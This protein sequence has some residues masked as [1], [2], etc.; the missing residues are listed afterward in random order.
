[1]FATAHYICTPSD[2]APV[3]PS[4]GKIPSMGDLNRSTLTAHEVGTRGWLGWRFCLV[5]PS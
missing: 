3:A 5:S 4:R 2:S 1:M